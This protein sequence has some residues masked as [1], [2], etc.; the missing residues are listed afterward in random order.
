[1]LNLLRSLATELW[2]SLGYPSAAG[3]AGGWVGAGVRVIGG[4]RGN[5][6]GGGGWTVGPGVRAIGA[7]RERRGVGGPGGEHRRRW[8]V[9]SLISRV[10]KV[11]CCARCAPVRGKAR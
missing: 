10:R 5:R 11:R 2:P 1:M 4:N 7:H 8:G 6:A 9:G 3:A